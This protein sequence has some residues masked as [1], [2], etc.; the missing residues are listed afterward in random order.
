[1]LLKQINM[2]I[3]I[4]MNCFRLK[5]KIFHFLNYAYFASNSISRAK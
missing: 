3:C 5:I 1:M 2:I 4:Q